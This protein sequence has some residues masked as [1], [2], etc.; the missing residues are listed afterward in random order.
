MSVSM[1]ASQ[2]NVNMINVDLY[3]VFEQVFEF[4]I[5]FEFEF[6][7]ITVTVIVI[8]TVYQLTTTTYRCTCMSECVSG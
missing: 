4:H 5:D 2:P 3:L 8:V 6:K 7:F 1:Y